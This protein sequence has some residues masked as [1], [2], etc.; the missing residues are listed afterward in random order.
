MKICMDSVI[1]LTGS[2]DLEE[3]DSGWVAAHVIDGA[4]DNEDCNGPGT[5]PIWTAEYAVETYADA[6]FL[7]RDGYQAA[8]IDWKGVR[9]VVAEALGVLQAPHGVVLVGGDDALVQAAGADIAAAQAEI[10]RGAGQ[11]L[12]WEQVSQ[13]EFD[14]SVCDRA[15]GRYISYRAPLFDWEANDA[16]RV[17]RLSAGVE[18]WINR[19]RVQEA[20]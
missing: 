4:I 5:F 7:E 20:A 6:A 1:A 16:W 15:D 14:D 12:D 3:F 2:L 11:P 10:E 8:D 18:Y 17:Q 13:R 9:S 19:H